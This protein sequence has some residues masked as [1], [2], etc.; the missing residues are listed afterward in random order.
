MN[1]EETRPGIV[2]QDGQRHLS[3]QD[4]DNN[5]K[6]QT[7]DIITAKHWVEEDKQDRRCLVLLYFTVIFEV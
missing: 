7:R 3:P 2:A 4:L 5:G 1:K 6:K